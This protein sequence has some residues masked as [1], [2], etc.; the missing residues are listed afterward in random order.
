LSSAIEHALYGNHGTHG[1][2]EFFLKPGY[3]R[4]RLA[5]W[6]EP[7]AWV[8]AGFANAKLAS[9]ETYGHEGDELDL[10]WDIIG[11]DSYELP[12]SRWCFVLHCDVIEW[13]FEAEWPVIE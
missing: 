8:Q 1:V 6:S 11:F 12:G 5:P 9:V 2:I 10:P 13:C 4:L 3:V 7:E